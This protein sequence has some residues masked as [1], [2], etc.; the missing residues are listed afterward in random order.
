M[1]RQIYKTLGLCT[2]ISFFL[3]S[4]QQSPDIIQDD[5]LGKKTEIIDTEDI[6][7]NIKNASDF[8]FSAQKE[9]DSAKKQIAEAKL[10]L[11]E[12]EALI[13]EMKRNKS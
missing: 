11:R 13:V 2:L 4:C 5:V 3:L 6:T 12:T 10:H 7:S 1:K 9:V 8:N